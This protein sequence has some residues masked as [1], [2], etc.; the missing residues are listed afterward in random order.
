MRALIA[1]A[2]IA[3]ALLREKMLQDFDK[4][5]VAAH[6]VNRVL[7]VFVRVGKAKADK[8]LPGAGYAGQK[9]DRHARCLFVPDQ[10]KTGLSVSNQTDLVFRCF[11]VCDLPNR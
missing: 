2:P 3:L 6:E 11:A 7:L 5:A 8:R 4:R 1:F 10:H 9:A